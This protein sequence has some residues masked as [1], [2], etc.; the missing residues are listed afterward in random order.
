MYVHIFGERRFSEQLPIRRSLQLSENYR[1]AH[2]I[3]ENIV[4]KEQTFV[5]TMI[6]RVFDKYFHVKLQVS[7]ILSLK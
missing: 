1:N 6:W 5:F 3:A 2:G 7:D 4:Y